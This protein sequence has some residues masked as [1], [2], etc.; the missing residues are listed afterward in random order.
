MAFVDTLQCAIDAAGVV[1]RYAEIHFG[2]SIVL[3]QL[4]DLEV[5]ASERILFV[6]EVDRSSP[7]QQP[8]LAGSPVNACFR[9]SSFFSF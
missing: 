5:F 4:S 6:F 9:S 3:E 2:F 8:G 1:L 7:L